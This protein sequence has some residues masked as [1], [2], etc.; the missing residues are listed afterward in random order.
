L[1][2]QGFIP[3]LAGID[4]NN[5]TLRR[6]VAKL[7]E[8]PKA[9]IPILN[10]LID[11]RLLS[12]DK[13]NNNEIIIEITHDTLIR[14]WDLLRNWLIEDFAALNLI[15]G[16][17][18]ASRDWNANKRTNDYLIHNGG[19]LQDA[20]DLK[21]REDFSRYLKY[22]DWE[23]LISS[24]EYENQRRDNELADAK[25]F[26]ESQKKEML[27]HKQKALVQKKLA[28]NTMIGMV[29]A[30][31]LF[32]FVSFMGWQILQAYIE[33][34]H[35]YGLALFE[36]AKQ[37]EQNKNY[38]KSNY[39][40]AHALLKVKDN[41]DKVKITHLFARNIDSNNAIWVSP[42][43]SLK[44]SGSINSLAYSPDDK[45][46]ISVFEE[47]EHL[48]WDL[49]TGQNQLINKVYK[50]SMKNII[51]SIDSRVVISMDDHSANLW[52]NS[53][54]LQLEILR[55][56]TSNRISIAT[57]HDNKTMATASNDGTVT[58]WDIE[59]EKIISIY[60]GHN[61]A[62]NSIT[63]SHDG[64]TFATSSEDNTIRLWNIITNQQQMIYNNHKRVVNNLAISKDS[65]FL[66]S[67]SKDNTVRVWDIQTGLQ[68]AIFKGVG[69]DV[70]CLSFSKDSK[71]ITT[72]SDDGTVRLLNNI[73]GKYKTIFKNLNRYTPNIPFS[74]NSKPLEFDLKKIDK[75]LDLRKSI[76]LNNFKGYNNHL[77]SVAISPDN[78]ILALA[79]NDHKV[80]L[81]N[82]ATGL[83]LTLFS[84]HKNQ[85]RS[86]IFSQDGKTIA[87]TSIKGD[88]RIWDS[89][90]GGQIIF[91][92]K[93]NSRVTSLAFSPTGRILVT[94]LKNNTVRL[95]DIETGVPIASFKGHSGDVTSVA[96]SSGGNFLASASIDNTVRIW[97]SES[98]KLI[99]IF[100]GH[101]NLINNIVF[102]HDESILASSS[103]DSTVRI[104]DLALN[105]EILNNANYIK[106][107]LK[108]QNTLNKYPFNGM[109]LKFESQNT[110]LLVNNT[111]SPKWPKTHPFHWLSEAEKGI[112]EAML[113][114]G[115]IYHR[116]S[117]N[118]KAKKWYTKALKAGHPK[119]Q[120]RLDILE[121]TI[122]M[123]SL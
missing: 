41:I 65:E 57:S 101:K 91:I 110:K 10:H 14:Q 118:K 66:A 46:L 50:N 70:M 90:T 30:I 99:A 42:S 97:D 108:N 19:R 92:D 9:S 104:W 6:R 111:K 64:R 75:L 53:I 3:W 43:Y 73:T 31:F 27:A 87:S 79:S 100:K 4:P 67:A 54:S 82:I 44:H 20:E 96:F 62:L 55:S 61:K 35:N 113:Q 48:Q 85:V 1:I 17:K 119:A 58:L 117:N 15:V 47:G 60:D 37:E 39:Y 8:I 89:E 122:K 32:L 77:N 40:S 115:I 102:S 123:E 116:N 18:R 25:M 34:N 26:A 13:N 95:W 63:F 56:D 38:N 49:T 81:W 88:V 105:N 69:K 33:T 80:G 112:E 72:A 68:I 24:R 28:K 83:Q 93:E 114:L 121:K 52:N 59:T 7:S 45:T 21:H 106:L 98:R 29:T 36:R 74:S 5:Q 86:I 16:I 109:A 51:Y 103:N 120:N 11:Q 12:T 84:H 22:K 94:G 107:W 76:K 78:K 71:H 2:R 23:Y